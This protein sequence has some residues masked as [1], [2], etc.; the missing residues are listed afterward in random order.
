M[1]EYSVFGKLF[2]VHCVKR[3]VHTAPPLISLHAPHRIGHHLEQGRVA[4]RCEPGDFIP[5]YHRET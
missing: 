1:D 3:L 4:L 2:G 5:E